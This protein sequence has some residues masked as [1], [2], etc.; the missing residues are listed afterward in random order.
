MAQQV[1][2][3]KKVEYQL[4]AQASCLIRIPLELDLMQMRS[5]KT[6]GFTLLELMVTIA[7]LGILVA[8][9]IPLYAKYRDKARS[10]TVLADLHEIRIAIELLAIDA[11]MWPG[12]HPVG[13]IADAEVWDLNAGG[14]GIVA[15]DGRFSN[16]YGPYMS[17][18]PKDPWGHDYFFDPDYHIGPTTYSV[19]GS[20][21]P[22]GT[23]PNVYDSDDIILH[24]ATSI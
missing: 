11:E 4:S 8:T 23:G 18:V 3:H 19:V 20:F 1:Q 22:N 2:K 14:A 13:K 16:W 17:S 7:I 21:G 9:A 5:Q 24:L 15:N 10:V 6:R 12:G